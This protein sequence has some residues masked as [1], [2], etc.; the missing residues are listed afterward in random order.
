MRKALD[1][2]ATLSSEI[3][4]GTG[5]RFVKRAKAGSAEADFD[6]RDLRNNPM[7]L[8]LGELAAQLKSDVMRKSRN[9]GCIID[10]N[11]DGTYKIEIENGFFEFPMLIVGK[12]CGCSNRN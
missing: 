12:D 8:K 5:G 9:L 7:I 2:A 6:Q 4:S 1:L 11:A 10:V 3:S